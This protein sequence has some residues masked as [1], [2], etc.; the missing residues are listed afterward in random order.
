MAKKQKISLSDNATMNNPFGSL[1][2]QFD[3][4]DIQRGEEAQARNEQ[5]KTA[6]KIITRIRLEKSGRGGKIVTVLYD[7]ENI[8]TADLKRTFK[9]VKKH[10]ATGGSF[11]ED[12]LEFQGDQRQKTADFLHTLNIQVKGQ[13][14]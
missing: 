7:W 6:D 9:Q 1:D 5:T 2:L 10:L 4:A 14:S 11:Q 12:S 13:L 8:N 3:S